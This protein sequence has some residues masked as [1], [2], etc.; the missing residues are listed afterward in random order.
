VRASI[1]ERNK[2]LFS[3]QKHTEA[4]P[5]SN[6]NGTGALSMGAKRPGR[7]ANHP[8]SSST[9]VKNKWS[10]ISALHVPFLGWDRQNFTLIFTC[11]WK[12]REGKVLFCGSQWPR[13]LRR[14]SAAARLL[15]FGFESR[16]GRMP[17][18]FKCSV[19]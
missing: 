18:S 17:V 19:L 9:E 5:H 10:C 1:P 2:I 15:R 13:G 3:P 6:S 8:S 14:K 7:E 12:Q 16:G 4:Y 11:V